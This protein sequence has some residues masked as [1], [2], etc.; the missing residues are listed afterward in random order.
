MI[1][2]VRL[3]RRAGPSPAAG[4]VVG[5][6]AIS[7]ALA[8]CR[9]E[10]PPRLTDADLR[11][12]FAMSVLGEVPKGEVLD[13]LFTDDPSMCIDLHRGGTAFADYRHLLSD[14]DK[15]KLDLG[16]GP[17][18]SAWESPGKDPRPLE[19]SLAYRL[20]RA[21]DRAILKAA[22]A[23]ESDIKPASREQWPKR[24]ALRSWFGLP[25]YEG[26]F[27]FIES[28]FSCGD[29]CGEGAILALEYREGRWRLIAK[30]ASWMA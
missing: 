6:A 23:A 25:G 22:R 10:E 3:F 2:S 29:L 19:P 4:V 8:G 12:V 17:S 1:H 20:N 24:C 13:K 18:R 5:L 14:W 30:K 27:A 15:L 26:R 16:L 9:R 21:E 7:I 11:S 28:G